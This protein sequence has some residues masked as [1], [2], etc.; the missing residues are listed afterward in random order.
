MGRREGRGGPEGG[1]RGRRAHRGPVASAASEDA[2]APAPLR[3]P[4]P[5]SQ[6][7]RLRAGPPIPNW[8]RGGRAPQLLRRGVS[9]R[10]PVL[11]GP[12]KG[13]PPAANRIHAP[14]LLPDLRVHLDPAPGPQARP[15]MGRLGPDSPRPAHRGRYCLPPPPQAGFSGLDHQ[16]PLHESAPERCALEP[17]GRVNPKKSPRLRKGRLSARPRTLALGA[18]GG[19]GGGSARDASAAPRHGRQGALAP[20]PGAATRRP[21]HRVPRITDSRTSREGEGCT[22]GHLPEDPTSVEVTPAHQ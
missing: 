2:R 7:S 18:L 20:L 11:I 1:H 19:G 8:V 6:D 10:T 16:D 13:P 14:Q 9:A 15:A 3:P 17:T 21:L 4:G 12:G 22:P 5:A